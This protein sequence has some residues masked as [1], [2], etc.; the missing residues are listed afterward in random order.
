MASR[1][2][3]N[4]GWRNKFESYVLTHFAVFWWVVQ[5]IAALRRI[6]NRLLIRRAISKTKP[7]PH[8][9]S[10]YADYTCWASLTDHKF[11]G[12]HMAAAP[13]FNASLP[14]AEQVEL[15]FVRPKGRCLMSP[16]STVLF[17]HFA[18]WFTDGFLRTDHT[19]GDPNAFRR[20]TSNHEIDL[21]QIYGLSKAATNLLREP[22]SGRLRSHRFD[23]GDGEYPPLYFL[24]NGQPDPHFDQLEALRPILP[25]DYP[26]WEE[27]KPHLFVGGVERVNVQIGYPMMNTLFLREHNRICGELEK[28][29]GWGPDRTFETA[30]NI[31][32]VLLLRIVLEEY[33]NHITPYHFKFFV[34]PTAF[35]NERWY[36][37][38]WMTVEF[39]LLYRWHSMVPDT[40]L[41][42]GKHR[43]LAESLFNNR[44]LVERGLPGTMQDASSQAAAKLGL[45]NTYPR[46]VTEAE[47]PSIALGRNAQL[48]SYN[49]YRELFSFPRVTDFD[50]IS[51]REEVQKALK[52]TYGRVDRIEFFAGLFAEDV[53]LNSAL[54]G[55]IGRMVGVDAFSQALTNPLLST[56][57]FNPDTF[58]KKGWEII[59]ETESLH[60]ILDRNLGSATGSYRIKFTQ[61]GTEIAPPT[62][63]VALKQ[64]AR[65]PA[66]TGVTM[67]PSEANEP[68]L[69]AAINLEAFESAVEGD[70]DEKG[71]FIK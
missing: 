61:D 45:F 7:R 26:R 44:L 60:Q 51:E 62:D 29:Y 57:V 16:K 12:R 34:D 20:N 21:S 13:E 42:A 59:H 3:I 36:R 11:S 69:E 35:G 58:S 39:N 9:F 15:L 5:R 6:F 24:P 65:A 31:L 23:N 47:R 28:E 27:R 56:N 8:Q 70:E 68:M 4:D 63:G 54:P 2:R 41:I 30:R 17:T 49:D 19:K 53:R 66:A 67:P 48:G 1:S 43:P 71:L 46:L 18:Q 38:N 22:A 55:L 64:L 50:Q 33:I 37:T 52:E 10:M 25:I 32:T 14:S 40:I